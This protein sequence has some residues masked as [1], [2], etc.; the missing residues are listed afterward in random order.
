MNNKKC[1]LTII[2]MLCLVITSSSATAQISQE[3]YS[4]R[5]VA[6]LNSLG[7]P[8]AAV[9]KAYDARVR[10]ND[11]N[12]RYRQESNFLYLT[13]INEP[14][15]YLL[16]IP[17]GIEIEGKN[18]E[19][20]LF[21]PGQEK[22]SLIQTGY[23]KYEAILNPKSFEKIFN[24]AFNDLKTLYV[25]AP[26]ISFVSDWLNGK[27]MFLE[28]DVRKTFEQKHPGIKIKNA[29]FLTSTLREIKSDAELKLMQRAID[30]TGDG[31]IN[32]IKVC[33]PGA[34]EYELRAAIEYQMTRQGADYT[35]F[36]SIIGSGPNSLI[37]H[38]DDDNRQM[39]KGEVVVMDVGAEYNGYAA[40]VTRTIPVSGKFSAAQREIYGLVLKAN[41]EII[42]MIKPG[43]SY[44]EM[45]AKAA[46]IFKEKG[47]E[48]FLPHGVTHPVGIDVH[49]ISSNQILKPG[50]VITV[51]P[52]LYLPDSS[53]ETPADYRG[54]GVRIEDDVLV[55]N[56][57]Y[58][59]LTKDIPKEI[60]DI[61]KLFAD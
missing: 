1:F 59:V 48:K 61:E 26:D 46:E 14:G 2:C 35:S 21:K 25:S 47:L 12:Y 42:Q 9:Y 34:W 18:A 44:N 43:I 20:L 49:D 24:G 3:E 40:D 54:I 57:G 10:S 41:K 32:A 13:G 33:K 17:R 31:I 39:K 15:A 22:D 56:D 19:I 27:A 37:L 45:N 50:M 53:S 30:M 29:A 52:G 23:G 8:S 7:S 28:R 5:R 11:V 55:T 6:L 36:P 4:S 38:Y 58:K 60:G 16:L 51:E